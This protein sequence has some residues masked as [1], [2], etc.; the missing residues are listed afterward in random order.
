MKIIF[1]A[2]MMLA[3]ANQVLSAHSE[4]EQ[5]YQTARREIEEQAGEQYAQGLD[6]LEARMRK[7]GEL[8][9]VLRVRKERERWRKEGGIP[10]S[11]NIETSPIADLAKNVVSW[12]H[13]RMVGLLKAYALRLE[14]LVRDLTRA[15]R[16]EEAIAAKNRLG[17]VRFMLADLETKLAKP[18]SAPAPSS[19]DRGGPQTGQNWTSPSTG[20][21][22]VWIQALDLWVGKFEVANDEYRKKEPA[23]N[24]GH[25]R[26][27]SMNEARQPVLF[28]NFDDAKA[29][30]EW[31]TEQDK[32]VL[33]RARY[34]LPSE[35]EWTTFAQ[36]GDGREYPWGNRWP[37]VSGRAG[38]Y[39]G[40]EGAGAW[41]KI[42]GY[43]DGFP[44]TAPVDKLWAN[45]W[46][47]H[48]AGGNVWEACAK[49]RS[50]S[51][52]GAWR[53]GSWGHGHEHRD[54]HRC[55]AR[56]ATGGSIR[57]YNRGFRLT[58]CQD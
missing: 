15:N 1:L 35:Q 11:A 58:L 49:D 54:D 13:E 50:G 47:L 19:S 53:G 52:F 46:G 23:H 20:M 37:P 41:S 24:S 34:R 16:M 57:N 18:A 7:A 17:A 30:A 6:R 33:G 21:T 12:R 28:V 31:M 5:R 32:N 51:S 22:F 38:N 14:T 56:R 39:H 42:H 29:Y 2:L 10:E 48:G 4:L 26:N 27:H 8:M 36:C 3:L 9:E 43:N 45:P 40:Q 25:Y 44:V 55:S